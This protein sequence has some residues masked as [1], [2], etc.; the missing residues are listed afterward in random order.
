MPKG[1]DALVLPSR[2]EPYVAS[3]YA[4][5]AVGLQPSVP[6]PSRAVRVTGSY[7]SARRCCLWGRRPRVAVTTSAFVM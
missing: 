5:A 1:L 7:Q 6:V 3:R 4:V 2:L